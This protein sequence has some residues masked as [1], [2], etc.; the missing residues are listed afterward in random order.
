MPK[1]SIDMIRGISPVAKKKIFKAEK[2]NEEIDIVFYIYPFTTNEKIQLQQFGKEIKA[3]E[4]E[5]STEASEKVLD[6]TY[7]SVLMVLK[8]SVENI[9]I[10]DIKTLPT[11][12]FDEII[13]TALEFEGINKETF[14]EKKEIREPLSQ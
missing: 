14:N 6:Y 13:S 5:K 7:R 8:K 1:T 2:D 3:L 4:K 10:E 9:T 12:W 11:S